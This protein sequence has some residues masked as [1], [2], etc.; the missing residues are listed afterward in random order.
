MSKTEEQARKIIGSLESKPGLLF[1]ILRI[2]T[3]EGYSMILGPWVPIEDKKSGEFYYER[4]NVEGES[5]GMAAR[6]PND[7]HKWQW[8]TQGGKSGNTLTGTGGAQQ[9]CDGELRNLGWVLV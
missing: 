7:P 8:Q 3:D 1:E 6:V 5:I 4:R 2:V 9:L